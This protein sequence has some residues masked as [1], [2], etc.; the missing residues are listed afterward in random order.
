[1]FDL[2]GTLVTSDL[3]FPAMKRAVV[4]LL[5]GYGVRMEDLEGLDI[6]GALDHACRNVPHEANA[7]RC[8][9]DEVLARWEMA[10]ARTNTEIPGAGELLRRLK[11]MGKSVGIITRNTRPAAMETLRRIPLPHDVL[12]CRCDVKHAKPHPEHM[13]RMLGLLSA[14]PEQSVMVGD[15][16][17]DIL[18]G[19][20]AGMLTVGV[21]GTHGPERFEKQPPD[22]VVRSV[23]DL[24]GYLCD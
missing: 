3:D 7:M 10:G 4:R 14:R 11:T 20:R 2:D 15:H 16:A 1:M 12:L 22:L 9:A 6:L 24:A 17:M 13:E 5:T 23:A 19:R 21:L 18:A 8:A